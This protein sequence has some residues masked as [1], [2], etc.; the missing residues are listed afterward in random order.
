MLSQ[1]NKISV[2]DLISV[3]FMNRFINFLMF[4]SILCP[5]CIH[6]LY[7]V[8]RKYFQNCS[9]CIEFIDNDQN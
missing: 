4:Y 3:V 6:T 5:H 1:L 8:W 9:G 2:R 7:T